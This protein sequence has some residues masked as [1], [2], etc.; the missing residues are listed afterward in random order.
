MLQYNVIEQ[1]DTMTTYI[2]RG[3]NEQIAQ[4][5][6]ATR[7]PILQAILIL[8]DSSQPATVLTD[9]QFEQLLADMD[10]NAVSVGNADYSRQ[11]IYS[12]LEDE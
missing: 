6:A 12:R 8:D 1:G 7:E 3:T 4:A 11:S 2:V 9:D 5:I 10:A